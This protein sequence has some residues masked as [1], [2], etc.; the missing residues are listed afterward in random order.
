[1]LIAETSRLDHAQH[2][3][4]LKSL[5]AHIASLKAALID[6]GGRLAPPPGRSPRRGVFPEP[7]APTAHWPQGPERAD[8]PARHL[9]T[10]AEIAR[11]SIDLSAAASSRPRRVRRGRLGVGHDDRGAFVV[12]K[13]LGV[14]D[15]AL[16]RL[17]AR[18]AETRPALAAP[19]TGARARQSRGVQGLVAADGLP[20]R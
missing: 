18:T 9:P 11:R 16:P 3:S 2:K 15:E 14:S 8:A 19:A 13:S 17:D 7:P 4:V 1:M 6:G 10:A 5:K 12:A 20:P